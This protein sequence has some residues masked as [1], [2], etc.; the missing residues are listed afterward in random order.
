M[1]FLIQDATPQFPRLAGLEPIALD[2]LKR[3]DALDTLRILRADLDQIP[4]EDW[5][6]GDRQADSREWMWSPAE[7]GE[8]VA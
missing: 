7:R 5:L 4:G 2:T 3:D 8:D 1:G 6:I